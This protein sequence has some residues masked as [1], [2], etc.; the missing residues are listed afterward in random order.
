MVKRSMSTNI[1]SKNYFVL[2]KKTNSMLK[3]HSMHWKQY[4]FIYFDIEFVIN[5]DCYY[6]SVP[7]GS[8]DSYSILQLSQYPSWQS[9]F[10]SSVFL[11]MTLM[12]FPSNR[13]CPY[14]IPHAHSF[15]FQFAFTRSLRHYLIFFFLYSNVHLLWF[16][17]HISY[18]KSYLNP[19]WWYSSIQSSSNNTKIPSLIAFNYFAIWPYI[20]WSFGLIL[21]PKYFSS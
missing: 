20:P 8:F 10:S 9:S 16:T 13:F 7:K 11:R 19:V 5:I 18:F 15:F 12:P 6:S 17:N 1:I 4:L 21:N 2:E 14:L 3:I